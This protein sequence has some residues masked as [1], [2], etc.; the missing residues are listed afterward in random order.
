MREAIRHSGTQAHSVISSVVI[1]S[2]PQQSAAISSHHE[3][4]AVISGN[5]RTPQGRARAAASRGPRGAQDGASPR[6]RPAR[7]RGPPARCEQAR[8]HTRPSA[9]AALSPHAPVARGTGSRAA[10]RANRACGEM[11]RYA[12]WGW[13]RL[14][15]ACSSAGTGSRACSLN[16]SWRRVERGSW[17][18]GACCI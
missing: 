1:S 10:R 9:A 15:A 11:G 3:Q 7:P 17:A 6:A 2:H 16:G 12:A 5:Q 14:S 8:S 18:C 13:G 4:S